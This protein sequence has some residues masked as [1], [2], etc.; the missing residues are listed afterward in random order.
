MWSIQK[1]YA[2]SLGLLA[3]NYERADLQ[4][5]TKEWYYDFKRADGLSVCPESY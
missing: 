2:E 3:E 1:I 5:L 4:S